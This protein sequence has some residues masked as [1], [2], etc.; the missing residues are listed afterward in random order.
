MRLAPGLSFLAFA[1][2]ALAAPLAAAEDVLDASVQSDDLA[3]L[4]IPEGEQHQTVDT[5]KAA[6][7]VAAVHAEA[8]VVEGK[9]GLNAV[10]VKKA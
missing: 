4:D 2:L 8:K 1:V 10:N 9:R 7:G 3:V 5:S 6:A